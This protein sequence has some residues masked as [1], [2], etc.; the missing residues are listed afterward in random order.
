MEENKQSTVSQ[1]IEALVDFFTKGNKSAFARLIGVSPQA[2]HD[3]VSGR[4]GDPSF[5]VIN[6]LATAFPQLR[7]EW[8]LTGIGSMLKGSGPNTTQHGIDNKDTVDEEIEAIAQQ[9]LSVALV[10]YRV[11][12]GLLLNEAAQYLGVPEDQLARIEAGEEYVP[13]ELLHQMDDTYSS[14]KNVVAQSEESENVGDVQFA[15]RRQHRLLKESTH[16][17]KRL[18][19]ELEELRKENH[20]LQQLLNQKDL[21]DKFDSDQLAKAVEVVV[22]RLIQQRV[23]EVWARHLQVARIAAEEQMAVYWVGGK[24]NPSRPYNGLL[25]ERLGITESEAKELVLSGQI[26]AKNIGKSN[27]I[28]NFRISETAVRRFLQNASDDPSAQ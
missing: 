28:T 23:D 24:A 9:Q 12:A 11:S 15:N 22:P 26:V 6:K 4:K 17:E 7:I 27:R 18:L 3:Y 16:R 25:S 5:S 2:V 14:L 1:R 10:A 19:S 13:T 20:R 21:A 8:L